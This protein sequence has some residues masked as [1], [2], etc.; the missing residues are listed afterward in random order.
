M[1]EDSRTGNSLRYYLYTDSRPH[2]G[3]ASPVQKGLIPSRTNGGPDL[4]EEGVGF[5]LPV[6]QYARDFYFPGSSTVA[7]E[8]EVTTGDWWKHFQFDLIERMY[9]KEGVGT[10]SWVHP[11]VFNIIYKAGPGRLIVQT[12]KRLGMEQRGRPKPPEHR[13]IRVRTRGSAHAT[14]LLDVQEKRVSVA[15]DLVDIF[16]KGLQRVYVSNE[17]GAHAFT[18]YIDSSGLRLEGDK[19]SPWAKVDARWAMLYAPAIETGF[20]VDIPETC[21]A[22]RGREIIGTDISWSGIILSASPSAKKIQYMIRFGSLKEL[23]QEGT[24]SYRRP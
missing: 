20:R 15:M 14:Y 6:L 8:G 18:Q 4:C 12:T 3:K 13:F 22:Y 5:G 17:L 21:I 11:R 7:R 24:R 1:P 16:R 10:F 9:K 19:I 23:I 2:H